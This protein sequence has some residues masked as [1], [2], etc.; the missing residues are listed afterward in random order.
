MTHLRSPL[1]FDVSGRTATADDR[2]HLRG[3]IEQVLFTRPGER[4][5]RPDFGCGLGALVFD[6]GDEL[7]A[8]ARLL[9]QAALQQWLG[10]H[11]DV[12]G[13]GA[14]YSLC[15]RYIEQAVV[16]DIARAQTRQDPDY[17]KAA[18]AERDRIVELIRSH[19]ESLEDDTF[20]PKTMMG[21]AR[22]GARGRA[23][24]GARWRMG[25]KW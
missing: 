17:A 5:C 4:V 21:A 18:M 13:G 11:I 25:A 9:P 23:G 15:A 2:A 6:A 14:L 1:H 20:E 19:N 12:G 7:V 24:G 10:D 22:A 16:V 8:A 3:L